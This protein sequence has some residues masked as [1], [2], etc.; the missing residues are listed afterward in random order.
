MFK[1]ISVHFIRKK[2]I[3]QKKKKLKTMFHKC[4]ANVC[5]QTRERYTYEAVSLRLISLLMFASLFGWRFCLTR[6]ISEKEN[7]QNRRTIIQNKIE[8]LKRLVE[9]RWIQ[10]K[11]YM[12]YQNEKKISIYVHIAQLLS[13]R[14]KC[15][16]TSVLIPSVCMNWILSNP[17]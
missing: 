6:D 11:H 7:A 9:Q 4:G 10:D 16:F 1:C 17:L 2:K 12:Y 8:N 3:T 14:A 15:V 5:K 13:Y